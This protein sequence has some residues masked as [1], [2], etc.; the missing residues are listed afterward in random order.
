MGDQDIKLEAS[1]SRMKMVIIG[2]EHEFRFLDT[3]VFRQRLRKN[4][5]L[6]MYRGK[7]KLDSIFN[8]ISTNIKIRSS[9]SDS[10][11]YRQMLSYV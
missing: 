2:G 5:Y 8:C 6:T 3:P 9:K 4:L 1:A 7:K 11:A 10:L